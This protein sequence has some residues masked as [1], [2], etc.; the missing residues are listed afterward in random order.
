MI[1][2]KT[3]IYTCNNCNIVGNIKEKYVNKMC[4]VTIKLILRD[5]M[6]VHV[7]I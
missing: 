5:L 4:F 1:W 7:Y 6:C 3:K 2:S